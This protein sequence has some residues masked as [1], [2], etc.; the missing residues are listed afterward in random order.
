[1]HA[2]PGAIAFA[3]RE[4]GMQHGSETPGNAFSTRS[5]N[6]GVRLI[7]GTSSTCLPALSTEATV[8]R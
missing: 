1:M 5:I 8:S 2:V 7:S 3:R 6:C 4:F